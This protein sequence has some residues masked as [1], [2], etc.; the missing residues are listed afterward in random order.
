MHPSQALIAFHC[1]QDQYKRLPLVCSPFLMV[2]R[3]NSTERDCFLYSPYNL[4]QIYRG[5]KR[6]R[7]FN[8]DGQAK[9]CY[10][11][12]NRALFL[13]LQIVYVSLT[14]RS[15]NYRQVF[16]PSITRG[17]KEARVMHVYDLS[18]DGEKSFKTGKQKK[19][20]KQKF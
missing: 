9:V 8:E 15:I 18:C 19:T 2:K 20:Q 13:S 4:H 11:T 14:P 7:E 16:I 17:R 5:R 6:I 1:H 3:N 12:C 10:F